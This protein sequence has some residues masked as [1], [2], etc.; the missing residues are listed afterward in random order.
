MSAVEAHA[1]EAGQ[2]VWVLLGTF[3]IENLQ[4]LEGERCKGVAVEALLARW[5]DWNNG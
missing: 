5:R 4:G 3:V 2:S 1:L